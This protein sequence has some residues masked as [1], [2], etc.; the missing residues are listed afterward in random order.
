MANGWL[1]PPRDTLR[2]T[3]FPMLSQRCIEFQ[4][5]EFSAGDGRE[6]APVFYCL[7]GLKQCIVLGLSARLQEGAAIQY[8]SHRGPPLRERR[9]FFPS[10]SFLPFAKA[11]GILAVEEF[12]FFE[13]YCT[14]EE[15]AD[16]CHEGGETEAMRLSLISAPSRWLFRVCLTAC[17][18]LSLVLLVPVP[19]DAGE[20]TAW[21][22]LVVP[23][24]HQTVHMIVAPPKENAGQAQDTVLGLT[25]IGSSG[26]VIPANLVS[27]TSALGTAESLQI[28]ASIP[29]RDGA[30]GP[31][32]FKIVVGN[33]S[34]AASTGFHFTE[35]NGKSLGLWDGKLPVL[36]YNYGV[37]TDERVPKTDSRRSRG[38]YIHPVYGLNGE[39]ITDDFPKD[40]YHHHGI[41]WSW[42]HV[43]IGGHEFDLWMYKNIEQR[44]VRWLGRDCGPA[45]ASLGVENGWFVGEKKVM[46]ERGLDPRLQAGRHRALHRPGI[47][48]DPGRCADR[49]ARGRRQELRRTESALRPASGKGDPDHRPQRKNQGGSARHAAGLGRLE[50]QVPRGREPQRRGDFRRSEPS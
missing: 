43:D 50:R 35:P 39:V 13:R 3:I 42:P 48:L 30:T 26:E 36:V 20:T 32:R 5:A 24:A 8:L 44:F 25:E 22:R 11:I 7:A 33:P 9:H 18:A 2:A 4:R 1:G 31:R 40:H 6:Y 12:A 19:S 41:F 47:H 27:A 45:T 10:R 17:G 14:R 28:A 21:P 15:L 16:D 29:P 38:C 34:G 23:A 46:I 49:A 37:I